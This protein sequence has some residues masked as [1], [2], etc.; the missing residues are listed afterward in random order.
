MYIW[1]YFSFISLFPMQVSMKFPHIHHFCGSEVWH[2]VIASHD[3]VVTMPMP[4][5]GSCKTNMTIES[6][7]VSISPASLNP[8]VGQLRN[9]AWGQP[10]PQGPLPGYL[11]PPLSSPSVILLGR[12]VHSSDS[13]IKKIWMAVDWMSFGLSYCLNYIRREPWKWVKNILTIGKYIHNTLL[14]I[15]NAKSVEYQF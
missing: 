9:E 5:M 6:T 3:C 11:H 12:W 8:M 7:L 14:H 2:L 1:L 4:L 10:L 13:K 15:S